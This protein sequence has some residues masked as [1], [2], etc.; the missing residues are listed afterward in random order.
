MPDNHYL[1]PEQQQGLHKHMEYTIITG[2]SEDAEDCFVDAKERLLDVNNW[3]KF[4]AIN[5]GAF[6]LKDTHGRE[7]SRH[8]RKGDHIRIDIPGNNSQGDGYDWVAIEAIEYDDYPDVDIETFA[9]RMR[10]CISPVNRGDEE[11]ADSRSNGATSTFVIERRGKRLVTA[12]Y[13][14]NEGGDM[15]TSV[16]YNTLNSAW[17]GLSDA[18][19]ASLIAGILEPGQSMAVKR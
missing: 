13:G 17:L 19:W 14:R 18:Q 1:V 8:A 6:R 7:I 10:P 4:T 2:N 15:E 9:M 3:N 12:Y 11:I 5:G 16:I